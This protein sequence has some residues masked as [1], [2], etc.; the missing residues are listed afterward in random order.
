MNVQ[1]LKTLIQLQAL[2]GLNSSTTDATTS[3]SSMFQELLMSF[4]TGQSESST[5]TNTLGSINSIANGMNTTE[6]FGFPATDAYT[7][8]HL[9]SMPASYAPV[10]P[11]TDVSAVPEAS[12]RYEQYITEAAGRYN[13]PA[14]LI[15]AVI[16]QESNFD[17][18]A[19]SHAGAA[20][21]MQLMPT[22]AKYVGVKNVFDPRENIMGGAKYLR[23]ML[24]RYGENTALALAAYNAGPGNVD[25]YSGIPPFKETQNYV[26]KV[27]GTYQA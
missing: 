10:Q 13:V 24:D 6:A 3:S 21:L 20:G 23:Q 7:G 9:S 8:R 16:K 15:S 25:K 26:Q 12:G 19:T 1:S 14:K 22:T 17:S 18:T 5:I 27:L 11:Y 4:L 2:Q